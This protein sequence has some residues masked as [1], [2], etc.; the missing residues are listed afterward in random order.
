MV[1]RW[2]TAFRTNSSFALDRPF[3]INAPNSPGAYRLRALA[4]AGSPMHLRRLA[5]VDNDGILHIGETT[6]LQRRIR[7]VL[8]AARSGSGGR[9]GWEF[10]EFDFNRLIP[11]TRLVCE[12]V[13][14]TSKTEAIAFERRLHVEYRRRYLD[15]PPL[16]GISGKK[17]ADVEN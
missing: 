11:L 16:D 8:Q 6:N 2:K 5:G 10:Y 15:R 9:A 7:N 1:E 14:T 3:Q 13:Q 4:P 17:M 12:Y